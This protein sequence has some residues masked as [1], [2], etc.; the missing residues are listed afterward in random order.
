MTRGLYPLVALALSAAPALADPPS[1]NPLA[2]E[3]S[4]ALADA[5]KLGAA[6]VGVRYLTVYNVRELLRPEY[7]QA[8]DF[9][10]NSLSVEAELAKLRRVTATLYAVQK[11][12]YGWQEKLF[13]ALALEDPYFHVRIRL[14]AGSYGKAYF[15]AAAYAKD[16]KAGWFEVG[17]AT[18][19]QD[20]SAIA[21]W[22]PAYDAAELVALTQ[23]AAPLLRLDWFLSRVAIQA[24]RKGTGYYDVL[25]IKK[26]ADFDK[27]IGFD[28]K[29]SQRIRREVAGIVAR[30]GVS[31]FPRQ[32]FAEQALTGPRIETRDSLDDNA[33]ARNA[34]RQL[35]DDFKRQAEET[36]GHL[37]NDLYIVG[38]FNA[39]GDT[40]ES[41]PDK[42]GSDKTAPGNDGRIHVGVSCFRC[43]VEGMRAVDDWAR[44]VFSGSLKLSSPDP[45]KARRLHQLYL[46]DLQG[47]LDESVGRYTRALKKCN[48]LTPAEN[49]KIIARVWESYV[50]RNVLPADAAAE[51]GIEEKEY[52]TILR[53]HYRENQIADHVLASHIAEPPLPLRIDDWEQLMPLVAPTILG[54]QHK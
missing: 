20:V 51:F 47:K 19:T 52:L 11:D 23:T 22:L 43:H 24:G 46:G 53:K 3:Q 9:W 2:A 31:N 28:R 18:A 29:E 12:D 14:T 1:Q 7:R 17:P 50:E 38:L 16:S 4:A 39:A 37:P 21:P 42:I 25:Q 40:Q 5:R 26:R 30:S 49:A 15:P 44:K 32:I 54:V 27:I 48:G 6:A 8:G 36:F 33:D 34:L 13:D 45:E 41:A 35:D 10:C